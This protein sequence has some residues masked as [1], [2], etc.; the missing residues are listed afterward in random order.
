MT[1]RLG[2]SLGAFLALAVPTPYTIA[3]P[4]R[5]HIS[6]DVVT[7]SLVARTSLG[8]SV[9]DLTPGELS[10]RVDGQAVRIDSLSAVAGTAA[11]QGAPVQPP[12][13]TTPE[14]TENVR[15]GT[16]LAPTERE[17]FYLGI[18][19]DEGSTASLDRRDIYRQLDR[20]FRDSGPTG[21]Q[22]MIARFSGT[23]LRVICP[24]TQDVANVY[25]AMNELTSNPHAPF[26]VSPE[27]MRRLNRADKA[28]LEKEI[29]LARDRLFRAVLTMVAGFPPVPARRMLVLV[30]S[31]TALIP[32]PDFGA[33]LWGN[34]GTTGS[35]SRGF[36][37]RLEDPTYELEQTQRAFQLWS[38]TQRRDWYGSLADLIAKAQEKNVSLVPIE[39]EAYDRG[40]NPGA[41]S[42]WG[43]RPMPGVSRDSLPANPGLSPRLP[44]S[45]TM[46][47]MAVQTGAE[48]IL[49]PLKTEDQLTGLQ[50]LGPY[51]LT[52]RDPFGDDHRRHR[53]EILTTRPG[54]TLAYRRGYR[55]ATEEEETLDG[56][57]VRLAGLAP[58]DNPLS[59][60]VAFSENP[61]S[62]GAPSFH[63][64]CRYKPIQEHGL[65]EQQ[66]RPVALLVAAEDAAGNRSDPAKWAGTAHRVGAT[67]TFAVD[68]D[69][70][71]PPKA[72][73]WSIAVRDSPTGLV[74]YLITESRS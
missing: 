17:P 4:I 55:T 68:F 13:T 26:F 44:V 25:A 2:F 50:A 32:P 47:T 9:Q 33:I 51:T 11:R 60:T 62:S 28:S 57:M 30:T 61:A 6:V 24:W 48:P 59:A 58:V 7:I 39:A 49:L 73:K 20:Y 66:E 65:E 3:Q 72:Y 29:V 27:A 31:G 34:G 41:E 64:S 67:A 12:R 1:A 22:F 15:P 10:L 38:G 14:P 46:M 5:E 56:L 40:T 36:R 70:Q 69:V 8:K 74:S 53:V 37:E 71:I 21:R 45:Q 35:E 43:V 18:M 63:L 54:V 19:I 52:F 42:K 16:G 23:N